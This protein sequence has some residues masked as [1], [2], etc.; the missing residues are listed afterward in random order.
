MYGFR[1]LIVALWQ[2][3]DVASAEPNMFELCR[4]LATSAKPMWQRDKPGLSFVV[5]KSQIVHLKWLNSTFERRKCIVELC[6]TFLTL[7]RE[8]Q[9]V[10]ALLSVNRNVYIF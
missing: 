1:G 7:G 10:V 2:S 4:A 8:K 6:S 3:G 5:S 9:N